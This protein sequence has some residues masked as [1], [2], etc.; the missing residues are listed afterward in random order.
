MTLARHRYTI[1]LYPNKKIIMKYL[2]ALKSTTLFTLA[3]IL[4]SACSNNGNI[5]DISA[6]TL[7]EQ[8]K[9]SET[10]IL[11]V[12]TPQ[13][14]AAA[15]VP[16]AINMPHTSITT[17]LE[18]LQGHKNKAI[19]IYCKS[20]HRASIAKQILADAGFKQLLHLDGD[21]DGW[22]EGNYPIEQ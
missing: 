18:K 9:N 1:K 8:L 13:E 3:L 20:G 15:H 14:Y 16:G 2:A 7:V 17:Q 12:R 19:V 10:L 11:D 5:R 22:L 21:M 6:N 4:L